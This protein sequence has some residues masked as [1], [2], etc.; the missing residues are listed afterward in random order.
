MRAEHDERQRQRGLRRPAR[1]TPIPPAIE[2]HPAGEPRRA[3]A[4]DRI[5]LDGQ[6]SAPAPGAT[7]NDASPRA[8]SLAS[9]GTI[10][11]PRS[12]R[13]ATVAPSTER[14]LRVPLRRHLGPPDSP[15]RR[16]DRRR[17]AR[18]GT[19]RRR[20]VGP[21]LLAQSTCHVDHAK[22]A[23]P[24]PIASVTRTRPMPS[25]RPYNVT[26][27]AATRSRARIRHRPTPRWNGPHH[28]M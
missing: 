24:V 28:G 4:A 16:G 18:T 9:R 20:S 11:R 13:A 5:G 7:A 21:P 17:S 3:S 6:G 2:G 23:R 15:F 22:H 1:T 12:T 26:A 27:R 8:E 10:I 14:F 19:R 25:A